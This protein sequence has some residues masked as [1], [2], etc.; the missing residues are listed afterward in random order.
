MASVP[1]LDFEE[2]DHTLR[3]WEAE[4]AALERLHTARNRT[5]EAQRDVARRQEIEEMFD[6]MVELGSRMRDPAL[7]IRRPK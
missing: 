4:D 5:E 3:L 7:V 6:E 2:L 1:P